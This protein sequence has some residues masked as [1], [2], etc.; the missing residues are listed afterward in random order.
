MKR[1]V[2]ALALACALSSTVLAG[3]V[4]SGD[5]PAPQAGNPVVTVILTI[6]S[7]VAK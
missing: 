6:I 7:I 2:M 5:A 4:P 1:F 3:D